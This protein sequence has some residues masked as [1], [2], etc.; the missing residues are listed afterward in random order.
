MPGTIFNGG[1]EM[2]SEPR[3]EH[4]R[5]EVDWALLVIRL[6]V[7]TI[8]MA[9][10]AQKVF[11]AFGG[12]GLAGVVQMMGPV[13]YPVAIGEFFGGLGL[14]LGVLSRFSAAALIVIMIGAI[15]MVHGKNGF[16][17]GEKPGFEYNLA[18]IG[19]LLPILIAG[20][21]RF[22]LGRLL[23]LPRVRNTARPIPVLE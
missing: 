3:V 17:L 15:V 2:A 16:F 14:A 6:I 1:T 13:G 8:F 7:G 12:P 22:T 19:L 9:H 20:P 11:G 5:P 23:P 10:G 21:G 4:D 18:L